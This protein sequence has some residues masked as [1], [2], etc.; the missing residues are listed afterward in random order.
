MARV[1][2]DPYQYTVA[3]VKLPKWVAQWERDFGMNGVG[4]GPIVEVYGQ[5][6]VA[7][8]AMLERKRRLAEEFLDAEHDVVVFQ[9]RSSCSP[10][11]SR[12]DSMWVDEDGKLCHDEVIILEA[13]PGH[14]VRVA[15]KKR[16]RA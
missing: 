12:V 1:E 7:P 14:L 9:P 2:L 3:L 10:I 13:I 5:Y 15:P 8:G 4:I 6:A 11:H 16:S